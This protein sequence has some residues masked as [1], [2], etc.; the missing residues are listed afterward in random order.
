MQTK[1][2]G[3]TP[4]CQYG[5]PEQCSRSYRYS[6]GSGGI[7][8]VLTIPRIDPTC[9]SPDSMRGVNVRPVGYTMWRHFLGLLYDRVF[10]ID[11]KHSWLRVVPATTTK[12]QLIRPSHPRDAVALSQAT[13]N[14][15]RFA[16]ILTMIFIPHIPKCVH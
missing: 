14:P 1:Y 15:R 3:A 2:P 4:C 8:V 13:C 5:V 16:D 12:S 10:E 6:V 11:T 7:V 9:I